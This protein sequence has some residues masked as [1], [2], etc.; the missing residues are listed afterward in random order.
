M[1]RVSNRE[2]AATML[3]KLL[4]QKYEP[5]VPFLHAR[6]IYD[7]LESAP[8]TAEFL[9]NGSFSYMLGE[10]D[11][12]SIK[13]AKEPFNF[14]GNLHITLTET[15]IGFIFEANGSTLLEFEG[16]RDEVVI[17]KTQLFAFNN[18]EALYVRWN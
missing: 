7:T 6:A 9:F 16:D 18:T 13:N 8:I 12:K 15:V 10:R 2:K 1:P 5:N 4:G 3:R 17:H 14:S 11:G